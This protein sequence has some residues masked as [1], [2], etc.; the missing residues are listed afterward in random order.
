MAEAGEQIGGA[1]VPLHATQQCS[2]AGRRSEGSDVERFDRAIGE[3]DRARL[4]VEQADEKRRFF[5][6]DLPAKV[7]QRHDE[8]AFAVPALPGEETDTAV[9]GLAQSAICD[10]LALVGPGAVVMQN[11]AERAQRRWARAFSAAVVTAFGGSLVWL[12]CAWMLAT[13]LGL[14]DGPWLPGTS[15][16]WLTLWMFASVI[17]LCIQW[18]W[19]SPPKRADKSAG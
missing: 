12:T 13:R 5:D 9:E 14:P 11:Q 16:S 2:V 1:E 18:Q 6:F 10:R 8:D 19:T 3:C 4:R 7:S 15:A 17:G